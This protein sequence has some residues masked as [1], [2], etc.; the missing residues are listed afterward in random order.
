L[1][2]NSEE[3]SCGEEY[4]CRVVIVHDRLSGA[5]ETIAVQQSGSTENAWGGSQSMSADG[6]YVAFMSWK[7]LTPDDRGLNEDLYVYD[8]AVRRFER[9]T[10]PRPGLKGAVGN[11]HSGN[12]GLSADGH[13]AVFD[14][15][16][17]N[18][19]PG[20]H[21]EGCRD[22]AGATYNCP[23]AFLRDLSV[24]RTTIVSLSS[25]GMQG[26]GF[27][28]NVSISTDGRY[29]AFASEASNLVPR[30]TNRHLDVFVRDLTRGTTT[31]VSRA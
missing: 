30:D 31:L 16:A 18:F 17:S 27:S 13:L 5:S 25:R 19:A 9:V 29:V 12:P 1:D 28:G 3:N 26:N 15:S 24:G 2:S 8:R 14:S 4:F 10:R 7:R 23:D 11:G 6:R 20:D 21:N 22:A